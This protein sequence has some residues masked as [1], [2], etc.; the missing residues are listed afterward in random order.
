VAYAQPVILEPADKMGMREPV[1]TLY[2]SRSTPTARPLGEVNP[3]GSKLRP[4]MAFVATH[5]GLLHAFRVDRDINVD[6]GMTAGAVAGADGKARCAAR[7]SA[8][9]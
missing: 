1:A 3:P 7:I 4:T 9:I 6:A 2:A 8:T 5:D